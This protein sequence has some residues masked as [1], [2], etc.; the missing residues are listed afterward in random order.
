M[1]ADQDIERKEVLS[2]ILGDNFV[3]HPK[4]TDAQT[5]IAPTRVVRHAMTSSCRT[6]GE[7]SHAAIDRRKHGK[8]LNERCPSKLFLM[9]SKRIEYQADTK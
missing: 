7:E 5:S 8:L 4:A 2:E 6:L 9:K 3:C 1:A